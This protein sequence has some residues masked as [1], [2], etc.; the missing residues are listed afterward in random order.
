MDIRLIKENTKNPRVIKKD[1]FDKLVNSIKTFPDMLHVRPLVINQDNVVL[2]GN[3]RLKALK[4]CGITDVPV[5]VVDW[6]IDKQ[7]EFIIKDNVSYGEWDTDTL[8][9]EWDLIQLDAW[10]FD[11]PIDTDALTLSHNDKP[12]EY[13]A[14]IKCNTADD[15]KKLMQELVIIIEQTNIHAIVNVDYKL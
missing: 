9:N 12:I 10:G 3:M 6:D 13:K 11:L 1:K 4:L 15:L 2:G 8:A 5:T 14:S 7:T